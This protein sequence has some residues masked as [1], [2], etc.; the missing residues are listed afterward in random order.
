MSL[1]QP[2]AVWDTKVM[3]TKLKYSLV[4]LLICCY[5]TLFAGQVLSSTDP[6]NATSSATATVPSTPATTSDTTPPTNPILIRPADGTVTG[7]NKIEFVW[8]QST[9]PNGNTVT[10]TLYLNGVATYLGVSSLGNSSGT[11]YSAV[12]DGNEVKLRPTIALPDG[13]YSWYVTATDPS[14]NTSFSTTWHLTIDTLAPPLTL[15]DLDIYHL[16]TITDGSNFDVTG[17][18]DIYFTLHSDPNVSIQITLAPLSTHLPST[19]YHLQSTTGASGL[20]YLYKHLIPGVYSVTIVGVDP[21]GNTNVLPVFTLTMT[22]AQISVSIPILPVPGIIIPY[23][24]ISLPSLP[25]TIANL[26]TGSYIPYLI[27]VLLALLILALLIFL[28]SRR[29]NFILIDANFHPIGKA[30]I[31]HSKPTTKTQFTP[32]LVTK[33]APIL[34]ELTYSDHGRL[35]ISGLSR[36]STLTIKLDHTTYILSLSA[37]RSLYT[38]VLG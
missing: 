23:T 38:I 5:V 35:Y 26:E 34:Y 2:K 25:A 18:K 20:A 16:P 19:L 30:T 14:Q 29:Y 24:P 32:V 27:P 8:Q 3:P 37:K 9:D 11:G 10:Y 7:D 33:R 13:V 28:W 1:A 31:Y 17:P 12:L 4:S 15:V 22:Q 21:S 6:Q 36:Y